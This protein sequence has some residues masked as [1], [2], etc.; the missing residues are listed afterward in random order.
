MICNVIAD[1]QLAHHLGTFHHARSAL[2][3]LPVITLASLAWWRRDELSPLGRA[4]L[5]LTLTG[6]ATNAINLIT[7]PAGVSDYITVYLSHYLI[8]F[9]PADIAILTGFMIMLASIAHQISLHHTSDP[10]LTTQ[11]TRLHDAPKDQSKV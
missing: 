3:V 4:A 5:A 6:V 9:N 2:L 7:D 1:H 8:A 10:P 11:H